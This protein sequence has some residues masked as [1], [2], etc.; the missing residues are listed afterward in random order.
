LGDLQSQ[1]QMWPEP[2]GVC[3]PKAVHGG[4]VTES[5]SRTAGMC[6][7]DGSYYGGFC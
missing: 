5:L 1:G 7:I 6:N 2:G 3:V 4:F